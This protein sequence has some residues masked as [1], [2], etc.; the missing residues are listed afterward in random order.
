MKN[1]A[2]FIILF[3]LFCG[4]IYW[5]SDKVKA[6]TR[7]SVVCHDSTFKFSKDSTVRVCGIVQVPVQPSGLIQAHYL[8]SIG[9]WFSIPSSQDA[10]IKWLQSN[11]DNR[12][13]IYGV[14]GM[15]STTNY[16]NIARFNDSC[17]IHGIET[18]F[19]WSK[20]NS[21]TVDLD[22][23]QKAQTKQSAR[24][25]GVMSELEPYNANPSYQLFWQYSR[26]VINYTRKN[27]LP[28]GV[29][30]GW[31]TQQSTDSMVVL[32]DFVNLHCYIQPANMGNSTYEFNYTKSR[33]NM[34]ANSCNTMKVANP[35]PTTIIF[36]DETAFAYN[37]YVTNKADFKA[38][39]NA[40]VVGWNNLSNGASTLA[41]LKLKPSGYTTFTSS[42]SL[43]IKPIATMATARM[44]TELPPMRKI[45]IPDGTIK[46]IKR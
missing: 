25:D 5:A 7:D 16:K 3:L 4:L 34:F 37:Y 35:F 45:L 2:K 14:D 36:S 24:F 11:G 30:V 32:Y 42:Y 1:I 41:K 19:V 6:Q 31:H 26:Q 18:Y 12:V 22:K 39:Y 17:S 46:L 10:M 33:V 40:Y 28:S 15:M 44:A 13:Y 23:F 38:P 27:K 43:K 20:P 29:Y 9:S 21:V 8:N